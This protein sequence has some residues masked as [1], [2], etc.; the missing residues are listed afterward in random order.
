L[1]INLTNIPEKQEKKLIPIG[2]FRKDA[3]VKNGFGGLKSFSP[4]NDITSLLEAGEFYNMSRDKIA[5]SY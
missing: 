4:K 5:N 3:I 1:K 2:L